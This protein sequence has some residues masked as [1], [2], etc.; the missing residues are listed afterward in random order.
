MEILLLSNQEAQKPHMI[1]WINLHFQL[2]NGISKWMKIDYCFLIWVK[3][4]EEK[5]KL[6]W[7]LRLID[8]YICVILIDRNSQMFVIFFKN[9]AYYIIF[10]KL[11]IDM[12]RYQQLHWSLQITMIFKCDQICNFLRIWPHLLKKSLM[13]NFIFCAVICSW[14]HLSLTFTWRRSLS[15]K[16]QSNNLQSKSMDWFL[17]DRDLRRESL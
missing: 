16:S 3:V 8:I 6:P 15:Y 1:P 14:K 7:I 10:I 12:A 5:R 17:N 4:V 11:N 9:F 13:E 2:K